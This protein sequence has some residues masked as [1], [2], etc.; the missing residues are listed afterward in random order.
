MTEQELQQYIRQRY[1][2]ENARCE[3]KE[4]KNLKN[5]FNGKEGNDVLSYVSAIANMEGGELVIGIKDKTLDIVGTDLSALT[6]NGFMATPLTATFKLVEQCVNLS[7]EG[8]RIEEFVTDDSNKTVWIIHIPKH[9]PRRPVYAHRKAWQRIADSLVEMT[10]EREQR[11]LSEPSAAF[12]DWSANI[13][14]DA[15]ID[16]LDPE[17]IR[18]ARE[19]YAERH[20]K[21]AKEIES[22]DDVTFLNK[23]KIT[24]AGK[25]TNAAIIL[26]GREESEHFL[27]PAVCIIRWKLLTK[28]DKNKDFRNFHIPMIKAVDEITKEYIRNNNYTYTVSGNIFPENMK[29]YDMFTLR[30]PINNAIG[31]QDYG[32][33]TRIELL[34]Y[35]DEKLVIQN[36]GQFIPKSV[37]DVVER[38]CPDS[39][40][41]NP[42]LMEAMC[43]VGMADT[44]GGGIKKLFIEQKKRFFPMPIYTLSDQKVRCEIQGKVLDENFARILVNNTELSLPE[45]ILL[46]KIQKKKYADL[47]NDAIALLRQKGFVEGRKT[48]LYLSYKVVESSKHI[49]LK[50]SYIK[51]KSFD[52]SYYK[53]LIVDYLRKFDSASRKEIEELLMDKLPEVLDE[54]QKYNKV[55]NLLASLRKEGKIY[56][57]QVE[58]YRFTRKLHDLQELFCKVL[59]DS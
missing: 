1:P 14:E 33:S 50:A 9:K 56:V 23:A 40:Y 19:K 26:L 13:I 25:I 46:D 28:D 53:K 34:E 35:E 29:R 2:E 57:K 6:F 17:A 32:M 51:N 49:G 27:S 54:T 42:F 37:E 30:E 4:M 15:T 20:E 10:S 59:I 52:D 3:W 18:M 45:I 41:R 11:I 8:L 39:R 38:D 31:H 47:T 44:E 55:T 7:S 21:R 24:R 12:G 22:W 48:N 36:Y 43:N 58:F 5:S 16:D